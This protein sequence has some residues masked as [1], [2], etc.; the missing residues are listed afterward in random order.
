MSAARI[1]GG[2]DCERA[3]NSTPSRRCSGK[4]TASFALVFVTTVAAPATTRILHESRV[5]RYRGIYPHVDV[6]VMYLRASS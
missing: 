6:A 4:P 5:C 2:A 3:K 1:T